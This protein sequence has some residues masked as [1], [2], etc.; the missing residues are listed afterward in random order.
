M[1]DTTTNK[2]IKI[3]NEL[4][5][6]STEKDNNGNGKLV[7]YNDDHNTFEHVI[8]CFVTICNLTTALSEMKAMIIHTEGKCIILKGTL[9]YINPMCE[10]LK[11]KGLRAET[12]KINE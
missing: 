1:T 2:D 9:A 4:G 11:M 7:V 5:L 3:N 10:A 12:E 8:H 6:F